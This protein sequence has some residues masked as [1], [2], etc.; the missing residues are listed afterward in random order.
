MRFPRIQFS[1]MTLVLLLTALAVVTWWWCPG[2]GTRC[3]FHWGNDAGLFPRIERLTSFDDLRDYD[4]RTPDFAPGAVA[5]TEPPDYV[6]FKSQDILVIP[7]PRGARSLPSCARLAGRLVVIQ[8]QLPDRGREGQVVMI[9][10]SA[11]VVFW[12]GRSLAI[13][14]AAVSCL[15]VA[16]LLPRVFGLH[17]RRRSA[18]NKAVNPS[19]GLGRS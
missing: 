7:R 5:L 17:Q 14:D 15:P 16:L 8:S 11:M 12:P 3:S 19:G 4:E 18:R 9:P 6:N 10:K 1:L 13:I 2:V